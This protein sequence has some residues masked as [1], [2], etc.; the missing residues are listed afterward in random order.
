MC[1]LGPLSIEPLECTDPPLTVTSPLPSPLSPVPSRQSPQERA[2]PGVSAVRAL[3]EIGTSATPART[4]KAVRTLAD[5][6]DDPDL[7][8]LDGLRG[9]ERVVGERDARRGPGRGVEV[10]GVGAPGPFRRGHLEVD[11]GVGLR[12]VDRVLEARRPPPRRTRC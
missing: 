12:G 11:S 1:P 4:P 2:V 7:G 5:G 9:G 6:Y 8:R 10:I 3:A